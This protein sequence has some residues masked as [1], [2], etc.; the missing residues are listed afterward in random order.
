MNRLLVIVSVLVMSNFVS[1][2]VEADTGER[3]LRVIMDAL[4]DGDATALRSVLT[5]EFASDLTDAAIRSLSGQLQAR[6]RDGYDLH[7]LGTLTQ[8][9]F[10]VQFWK[11]SFEDQGEDMLVRLVIIDG[12]V[13]GLLIT[14]PFV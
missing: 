1:N 3:P 7:H 9:D 11:L 5:D 6:L 12:Q 13:A 14:R 2:V 4:R 8:E 10:P